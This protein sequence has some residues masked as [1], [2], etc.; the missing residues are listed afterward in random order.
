VKENAK[1]I[2]DIQ[3]EALWNKALAIAF[4]TP[5]IRIN[6]DAYLRRTLSKYYSKSKTEEAIKTTP[7][8][9]EIPKEMIDSLA[10]SAIRYHLM[11]VCTISFTLGLPGKLG[12]LFGTIPADLAQIIYHALILIQKLCYLYGW[13]DFFDSDE[14]DDETSRLM[15][16][17][18]GTMF[19]VKTAI[20][21]VKTLSEM[22]AKEMVRRLPRKALTRYTLFVV[23]RQI[24]RL[25]G[26]KLTKMMFAKLVGK[27]IPIVGGGISA[28]ISYGFFKRGALSLKKHL[29]ELVLAEKEME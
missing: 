18:L 11:F 5:G 10:D 14:L 21:G 1:Q 6:R 2:D 27:A 9:A 29:R 19:G 7:A 16:L 22:I 23:S 24:A 26:I 17:F 13:P 3:A 15:T 28:A 4:K 12:Y 20:A 8:K 25:I